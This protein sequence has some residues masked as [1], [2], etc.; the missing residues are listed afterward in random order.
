MAATLRADRPWNGIQWSAVTGARPSTTDNQLFGV[1]VVSTNN[2]WAVG[3]Y[4]NGGL[5]QDPYRA[6]ERLY[7]EPGHQ[8]QHG[9]GRQR[10]C[11]MFPWC[12]VAQAATSGL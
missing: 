10:A 8:P 4:T 11:R 3:A 1:A 2:V 7:L 12:R 6:L 5:E 9:H